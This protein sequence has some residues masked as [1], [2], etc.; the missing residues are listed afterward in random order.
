MKKLTLA[1]V[2]L[3]GTAF[4]TLPAQ[5]EFILQDN[6]FTDL[7]A[8]GFGN[9]PPLLTLQNQG[10]ESG[11]VIS[12][13]GTEAFLSPITVTGTVQTGFTVV[14]I[15][16]SGGGNICPG[17]LNQNESNLTNISVFGWTSGA[18]VGIGLNTNQPGSTEGLLFNELVLNI[19]NSAG[20][21]VG[22]FG[23]ND[24][25]LITQQQL[26]LQQGQGNAV[27]D[28]ALTLNEQI[29]FNQML[30]ANSGPLFAGLAASLGC[31]QPCVGFAFDGAESFLG[32]NQV[33]VPGPVVGMGLPGLVSACLGLIGFNW[34]RRRRLAGS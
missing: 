6:V 30:A 17:G 2:L 8:T 23:G 34:R 33:A 1:A 4:A 26:A 7:S 18:N 5:A 15:A 29:E 32:F 28:L 20:Q 31:V 24:P 9:L 25:V 14:G 13:N 12:Q 27:F 21:I 19:Y 10:L 3:A 22:T 11:A 16:C